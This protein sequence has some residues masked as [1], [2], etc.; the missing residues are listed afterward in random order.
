[1]FMEEEV[2]AEMDFIWGVVYQGNLNV[3]ILENVRCSLIL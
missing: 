1:M 3:H 2:A